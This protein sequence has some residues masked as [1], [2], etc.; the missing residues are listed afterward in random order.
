MC[1]TSW[2]DCPRVIYEYLLRF[3]STSEHKT[4]VLFFQRKNYGYSFPVC[5][6]NLTSQFWYIAMEWHTWVFCLKQ[7]STFFS[8]LSDL[9]HQKNIVQVKWDFTW[10]LWLHLF[11]NNNKKHSSVL[12]NYSSS[13]EKKKQQKHMWLWTILFQVLFYLK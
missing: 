11:V 10:G 6:N 1:S 7:W 8:P 5:W 4:I 3:I 9:L 2:A 12:M 13:G